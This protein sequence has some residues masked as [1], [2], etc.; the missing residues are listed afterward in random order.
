[1]AAG[2]IG[3]S[4]E[5]ENQVGNGGEKTFVEAAVIAPDGNVG[6]DGK[7]GGEGMRGKIEEQRY[8]DRPKFN[9]LQNRF[10]EEEQF[11]Y[12]GASD[13]GSDAIG[14]HHFVVLKKLG[15][16]AGKDKRNQGKK[17]V[18]GGFDDSVKNGEH[19]VLF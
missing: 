6:I 13:N 1:M 5:I 14:E 10:F 11:N 15:I 8:A 16:S 19:A 9:V 17:E 2:E 3:N 18:E 12:P 7:Y 4:S